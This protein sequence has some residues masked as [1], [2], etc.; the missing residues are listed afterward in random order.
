MKWIQ[1]RRFKVRATKA[2]YNSDVKGQA[3]Y[4][5]PL[6]SSIVKDEPGLSD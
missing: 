1:T 6:G 2:S 4:L 5:S 3:V